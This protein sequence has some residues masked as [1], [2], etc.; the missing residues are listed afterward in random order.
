M[1]GR[2]YFGAASPLYFLGVEGSVVE[3]T[4]RK[5]PPPHLPSCFS[6]SLIMQWRGVTPPPFPVL[7]S[8]QSDKAV[9]GVILCFVPVV[10]SG[11]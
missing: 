11:S 10:F 5:C 2:E 4:F 3:R 8:S 7:F 1:F 6:P 9:E